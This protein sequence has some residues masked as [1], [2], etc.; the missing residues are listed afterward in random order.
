CATDVG[1]GGDAPP[2][3]S[4]L[5]QHRRIERIGALG[6]VEGD[7]GDMRVGAR[8]FEVDRHWRVLVVRYPLCVLRLARVVM[9]GNGQRTTR[10]RTTFFIAR[11]GS[12]TCPNTSSPPPAVASPA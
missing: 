9:G 12:P 1:V 5:G 3:R 10:Q 7:D 11:A 4:Q 8:V 2:R 6:T